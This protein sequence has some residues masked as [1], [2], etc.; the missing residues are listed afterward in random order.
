[1]KKMIKSANNHYEK[2]QLGAINTIILFISMRFG[3]AMQFFDENFYEKKYVSVLQR[4]I[5]YDKVL[6]FYFFDM[7]KNL[8][9]TT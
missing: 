9:N 8:K 2:Y 3:D 1:M 4:H 7:I 6:N 5:C